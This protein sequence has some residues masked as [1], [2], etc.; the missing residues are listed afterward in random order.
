M[1]TQH[2]A[3]TLIGVLTLTAAMAFADPSS[4]TPGQTPPSGQTPPPAKEERERYPVLCYIPNRI[5]DVLDI[6][7]ARVR[8][9]PGFSIGAR[10]TEVADVFLGAH[11][12][13]YVGLRGSRGKPQIPWPLGVENNQGIEVSVADATTEAPDKPV[14]DPLEVGVETQLVLVGVN[15]SVETLEIV[16]LL[17]GFIFIDI[18]G[19]DF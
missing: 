3:G 18:R 16:D 8:I 13:V 19:D 5:F 15:V 17:A 10:V 12:T 6:V 4:T 11:K 14:T 9:G 1:N 7:R 2:R